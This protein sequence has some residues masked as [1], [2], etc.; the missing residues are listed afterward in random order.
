MSKIT[1]VAAITQGSSLWEAI[2]LFAQESVHRLIVTSEDGSIQQFLTQSAVVRYL[3]A[4]ADKLG[5]RFEKTLQS[6]G[7]AGHVSVFS[8]ESK[9]KALEAFKLISDEKLSAVGVVDENG[10]LI[11]NIS[12]RDIRMIREDAE[13]IQRLY[14]PAS[15]FL[16]KMQKTFNV[17]EEPITATGQE[18]VK[19]IILRLSQF[20]IHRIYVVDAEKKPQRVVSMT[21]LLQYVADDEAL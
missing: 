20:R 11:G 15:A 5:P 16:I 9:D 13:F 19:D 14:L 21:D 18:T 2:Q 7:L 4:N 6:V 8:V 12:S 1:E 3:A 10:V 17:P